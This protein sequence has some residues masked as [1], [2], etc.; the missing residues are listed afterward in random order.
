MKQSLW[1]QFILLAAAG[2]VFF[3]NLGAT[4][5]FDLDEALF[6]SCSR[7][8][9]VHHD[10][11]VPRYNNEVFYDKPPLMYWLMMASF[12]VLGSSEFAARLPMA[13]LAT[14]TALA[15]YHIGRRLF[16]PEIGFWAG[17]IMTSTIIFTVSARAATVDAAL[18]CFTV[19]AMLVY[20]FKAFPEGVF[21]VAG[22]LRVPS[23]AAPDSERHAD[24]P[25]GYPGACYL[26]KVDDRTLRF[27]PKAW[28]VYSLVGG[29]L[30]VAVLGK[31]PV[32]L[33]LPTLALLGFLLIVNAPMK[34]H[35]D[36]ANDPSWKAWFSR[37]AQSIWATIHPSQL[38]RVVRGM[39]P[40]VA[41]A[42]ASAVAASMVCF[43]HGSN[44]WRLARTI[45][46]QIQRRAVRSSISRA[47]W[48]VLLSFP[49]D[50][51]RTFSVVRFS[52]T[53]DGAVR[54]WNTSRKRQA[55]GL[56]FPR[57]L[58]CR[59]FWLLVALQYETAALRVASL[60]AARHFDRLLHSSVARTAGDLQPLVATFGLGQLALR[61][62]CDDDRAALGG[63]KIRS[64][65]RSH[66]SGWSGLG[67]RR[68]RRL[69]PNAN[70]PTKS[71]D[72]G[73]CAYFD[74]VH[75]S[76]VRLG[77]SCGLTNISTRNH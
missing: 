8:M 69:S 61:G 51:Y 53:D 37:L 12:K 71:G 60:C 4:G 6:A 68:R 39:R 5:L 1:H 77:G 29:L 23:A 28:W 45:C 72:A 27:L 9:L 25:G 18:T 24:P 16:K 49:R 21:N 31:G 63:C 65:R 36:D 44:S 73:L 11:V 57:M 34:A 75:C 48:S 17:M 70:G 32:G 64:R 20:V 43:G 33:L 54:A 35:A 22:T 3:T 47:S 7:E 58:G 59:L 2:A 76:H 10:W 46:L 42:A 55:S 14:I 67:D 41:L 50:L 66:R 62:C 56:C 40:L 13:I 26:P 52:R 19:L 38:F 74:S 15:T 30:G